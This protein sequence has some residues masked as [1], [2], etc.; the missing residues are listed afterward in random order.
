MS[1]LAADMLD[2]VVSHDLLTFSITNHMLMTVVVALLMLWVFQGLF[3]DAGTDAPTGA[4]NFFEAIVEFL[5]VEVFR[6]ALKEHTDR[7]LPFL[8]TLF[9]FILF[10]NILGLVP[11]AT[12]VELLTAGRI[13][14]IGGTVTGNISNTA[15]LAVM[16]FVVIH[17][18]G[19]LQVMRDLRSG[20]Y[21]HHAAHEEHSSNGTPGHEAAMDLDHMRGEALPADVPQRFTALANPTGHYADGEYP[22]GRGAAK[23]A[24][25]GGHIDHRG[26]SAPAAAILAIPLYIWNFAPHP[27]RPAKGEPSWKWAADIPMWF[28]LLVLEILGAFIKPFALAIRLFANMIAGH[29]VLAALLSLI[30]AGTTLLAQTGV[31]VPVIILSLLIYLL[32]VLVAFLQTYIFV[33]LAT[34]FIASAVAPEH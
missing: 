21:G 18:S 17:V 33:F 9:F 14:H 26:M 29:M 5:R 12:I 2:H 1:I 10:S 32:D 15:A 24:P 11:I 7:F 13:Q 19:V 3:K 20:T 25:H 8:L 34:L 4:R 28:I 16:V 23:A 30:V 27:F 31:A 6:P 22:G